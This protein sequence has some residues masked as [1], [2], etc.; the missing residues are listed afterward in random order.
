MVLARDRGSVPTAVVRPTIIESS[1]RAPEP[2]WLENLNVG[3]P[4]W[5]EYGRGRMP[6]FPFGLDAVYDIVPVDFVAHAVL[7]I[8]PGLGESSEIGYY[9]VGSGALNPI[10]GADIYELTYEYFR[11]HPMH[12]RRGEPIEA[13]RLTFPTHQRFREM[14]ADEAR[15]SVTIA[16]LLYL[17][18]LYET[19]MNSGCVFDTTNTQRLLVEMHE[20]DRA[21]LDFDV[22]RIDW[23]SYIQE[24]HLPGLRRHVLGD[25]RGRTTVRS[26]V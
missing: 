21:A 18:D 25:A 17:A 6:D 15:R 5:V 20:G 8:L 24:V 14:Y 11:R 1:L 9:A 26:H 19:Y 16:R 7:A 23:R 12:N 3:D 13:R 10:T 4:I 2:G 22:R